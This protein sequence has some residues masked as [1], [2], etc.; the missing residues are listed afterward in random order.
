MLKN[1]EM[2][3]AHNFT[4]NYEAVMKKML[5][6]DYEYMVQCQRDGKSFSYWLE[7]WG[8]ENYRYYTNGELNVAW[9]GELDYNN[10][11]Y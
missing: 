9:Y 10:E 5:K 6:S 1:Y 7:T 2:H 4:E 8:K 3:Y 11:N